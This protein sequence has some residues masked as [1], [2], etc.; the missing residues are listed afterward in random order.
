MT[1]HYDHKDICKKSHSKKHWERV[2][3][4]T[5]RNTLFNN[6]QIQTVFYFKEDAHQRYGNRHI[7]RLAKAID[8]SMD[9]YCVQKL[10]FSKRL[11]LRNYFHLTSKESFIQNGS[12]NIRQIISDNLLL[13]K[14]VIVRL[15]HVGTTPTRATNT[16]T[17]EEVIYMSYRLV[18]EESTITHTQ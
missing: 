1:R 7:R 14:G 13:N 16:I 9:K 8:R 6:S 5:Q 11:M 15:R 2:D 17:G 18:Y 3:H 12:I 10:G 4:T